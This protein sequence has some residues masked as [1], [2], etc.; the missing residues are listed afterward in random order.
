VKQ[1]QVKE[2]VRLL[3]E[4]AVAAVGQWTYM[5]TILNGKPAEVAF[6]VSVSFAL[7]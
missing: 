1:V 5:R 7:N 2:S 3:D 6:P 4:A